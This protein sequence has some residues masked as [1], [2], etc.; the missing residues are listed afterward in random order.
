VS[1]SDRRSCQP[2]QWLTLDCNDRSR[3]TSLT[4]SLV[5]TGYECRKGSSSRWRCIVT[6]HSRP[7]YNSSRASPKRSSRHR[8]RSSVTDSLF[9]PAVRL[10]TVGRRAFPVSAARIWNDLPSDWKC[11]YFVTRTRD[12]EGRSISSRTINFKKTTVAS[13]KTFLPLFNRMFLG[14]LTVFPAFHESSWR[15]WHRNLG[16]WCWSSERVLLNV[17]D[18]HLI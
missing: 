6:L 3:H 16:Q 8:L 12:Y 5:F 7:T 1:L 9:V 17:L 15:Q 18:F 10:S 14:K 4:L 11:T 2:L 13:R